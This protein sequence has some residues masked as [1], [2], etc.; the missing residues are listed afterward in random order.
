[1]N[2]GA[3][4]TAATAVLSRP[5]RPGVEVRSPASAPTSRA[6]AHQ[7]VL[8]QLVRRELRLLA[9]LS[10]WAPAAEPARTRALTGHAE[11]IGRVLLHHHRVERD[12]L[13]PALQ[14]ALPEDDRLRDRVADWTAR[15]ARI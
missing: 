9:E 8:H 7:R 5:S 14:R 6:V 3:P 1:M 4:M 15:C 10:T 11:L 12:L 2:R 13:W